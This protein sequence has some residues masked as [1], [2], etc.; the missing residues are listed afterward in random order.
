M[1]YGYSDKELLDMYYELKN[2]RIFTLKMQE[3][4]F[5]GLIRSCFHTPYGQEATGVAIIRAMRDTDWLGFTHRL[6]ISLIHRYGMQPFMA[7]IFGLR[8][9]VLKGSAFDFHLGDY[10]EDGLHVLSMPGTLGSGP[11]T[12]AG[13]AWQRK[14]M[15]KDDVIVNV[16]G[17]GCCS[18]GPVYEAWNLAV[19]N[20]LPVL[21]IIENNQWQISVPLKRQSANFNICEKAGA[22]GMPYEIVDGTNILE[23]RKTIEE[24]IAKA[25]K[26]EPNVI[27]IKNLR[28]GPHFIGMPGEYRDDNDLIEEAMKNKDCVKIYEQYLMDKGLID[29]A[30]IDKI[31]VEITEEINRCMEAASK[32]EKPTYN[33]IYRKEYIYA[34]PETGGDL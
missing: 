34:N 12:H 29:Q 2:A 26:C 23:L 18:E 11:P 22:C 13:F 32:S 25:R 4:V 19:L 20:K 24:G 15:G 33:D 1:D 16:S 8:D 31:T 14:R 17:E 30:Y 10:S 7:E 21:F 5:R 3:A 28:W 6:Q 27:E 9:G